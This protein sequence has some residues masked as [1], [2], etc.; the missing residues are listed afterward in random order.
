MINFNEKKTSRKICEMAIRKHK[1]SQK[2]WISQFA[3]KNPCK[4][5]PKKFI[6]GNKSSRKRKQE[7]KF[8]RYFDYHYYVNKVL[9]N[10]FILHIYVYLLLC[11]FAS[12]F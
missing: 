1:Y 8:F 7:W 10:R 3:N 2:I 12:L 9:Q 4:I 6:R 5:T 11:I